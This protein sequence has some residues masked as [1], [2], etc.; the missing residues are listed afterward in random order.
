MQKLVL[1]QGGGFAFCRPRWAR[2]SSPCELHAVGA[3]RTVPAG[4]T[5]RI[6]GAGTIDLGCSLRRGCAPAAT[7]VVGSPISMMGRGSCR[8]LGFAFLGDLVQNVALICSRRIARPG[9]PGITHDRGVV[10]HSRS[11]AAPFARRQTTT[12]GSGSGRMVHGG[13]QV[14]QA[15]PTIPVSPI[16]PTRPRGSSARRA[17]VPRGGCRRHP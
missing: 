17:P 14:A 7:L 6:P 15:S 12:R 13:G 1:A 4:R 8:A 2:S 11:S 5:G 16:L 9:G 10:H 3:T